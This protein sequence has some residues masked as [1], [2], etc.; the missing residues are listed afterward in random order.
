MTSSERWHFSHFRSRIVQICC[1]RFH[2]TF[3][4]SRHKLL[5]FKPRMHNV[6]SKWRIVQ[7]ICSK[8][9][10]W[11][12]YLLNAIALLSKNFLPL[13]IM[14]V[15]S[16]TCDCQ[17]RLWWFVDGVSGGCG[18]GWVNQDWSETQNKRW[19]FLEPRWKCFHF[20]I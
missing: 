5:P 9:K 8:C 18:G 1:W 3:L 19:D 2:L 17:G 12:H 14:S 16:L 6:S 15:A 4:T 13:R 11:D 20:K 7:K 10:T